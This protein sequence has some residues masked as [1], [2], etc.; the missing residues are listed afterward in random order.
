MRKNCPQETKGQ[1]SQARPSSAKV[2]CDNCDKA[3]HPQDCCFDL[4]LEFK[5]CDR[6]CDGGALQS[7]DG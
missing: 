1:S 6:D 3:D 7:Q 5:S 2:V 4:H